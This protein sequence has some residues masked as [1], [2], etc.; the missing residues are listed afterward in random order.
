M[1]W[2]NEEITELI[3]KFK[4]KA[5]AGFVLITNERDEGLILEIHNEHFNQFS[6]HDRIR[7]AEG[8]LE[9]CQEIQKT[10]CPC[11]IEKI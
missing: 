6:L 11:G 5:P 8:V 9:L 2:I 1:D 7:I 10:G 4:A 3:Y